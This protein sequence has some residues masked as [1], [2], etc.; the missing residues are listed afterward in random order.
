MSSIPYRPRKSHQDDISPTYYDPTH[1][2]DT[3]S[4]YSTSNKGTAGMASTVD[5]FPFIHDK[6][7]Y[8]EPGLYNAQDSFKQMV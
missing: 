5:R 7:G 8:P 2:V 6:W 3:K 1:R 4:Q